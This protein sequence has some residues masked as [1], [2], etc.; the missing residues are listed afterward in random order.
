MAT[1]TP[2]WTRPLIALDAS[3]FYLRKLTWPA[4][5]TIIYGR[6]PQVVLDSGAAYYTW[7]VPLLVG[8]IAWSLRR[9]VRWLWLGFATFVIGL[10]PVLG[11][12]RFMFQIHST[13]ADH[14]LYLPMLGVAIAVAGAVSIRPTAPVVCVAAAVLLVLSLLSVIQIKH[15]RDSA[16]LYA[17]VL[18]IH[19]QSAFAHAGLGRA[20]AESNRIRDAIREFEAAV[21]L[22]PTSR[23]AHASLAQAYLLDGRPTDAVKH[24]T[25]AI[26]LAAPGA[27]TSWERYI[28]DQAAQATTQPAP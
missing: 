8:A 28:L 15:W 7:L 3:A 10:L 19:P 18:A 21:R 17:R 16:S 23:T 11:F 13:V 9:R 1:D 6:T 4:D 25:I 26:S 2:L 14:Y 27:D 12:A 5:L 20:Y 24:A 22:A